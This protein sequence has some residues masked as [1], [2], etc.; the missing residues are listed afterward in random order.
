MS[1]E[2]QPL[3]GLEVTTGGARRNVR[4]ILAGR[5]LVTPRQPITVPR[6]DGRGDEVALPRRNRFHP[7]LDFVRARPELFTVSDRSDKVTAELMLRM[8]KRREHE[9]RS[10]STRSRP[11]TAA[12]LPSRPRQ[13]WRLP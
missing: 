8:V 6:A 13:T 5:G 10:G 9:I 12:T 7:S 1:Y 3:R 4:A 11:G 2:L